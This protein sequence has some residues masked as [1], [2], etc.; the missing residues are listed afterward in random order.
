VRNPAFSK[1]IEEL[2]RLHDSKSH[3]Y[4]KET[5]SLANLRRSDRFGVPPWKGALVRMSDKWARI[6][7]LS[8]GKTPKHESLRDSLID[9]ALYSLLAIQLL[10]EQTPAVSAAQPDQPLT[11]PVEKFGH[12]IPEAERMRREYQMG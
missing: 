7:E 3:D 8:S 10:D 9:N 2:Q 4:A 5:D 1:L 12:V 11:E 6:E